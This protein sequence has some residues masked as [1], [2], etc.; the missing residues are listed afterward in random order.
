MA[1]TGSTASPAE[2]A[3]SEAAMPSTWDEVRLDEP[4]HSSGGALGAAR[5]LLETHES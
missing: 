4:R 1:V 3:L 2:A 5:S